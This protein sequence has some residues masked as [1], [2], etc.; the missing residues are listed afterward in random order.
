VNQILSHELLKA[1]EWR[2]GITLL[3]W[4]QSKKKL[5]STELLLSPLFSALNK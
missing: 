3:E 4:V 5:Q 1:D 2:Y